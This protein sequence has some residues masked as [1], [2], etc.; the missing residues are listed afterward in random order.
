MDRRL[1]ESLDR[2][3]HPRAAAV[4]G[5]SERRDS[6]GTLLLRSFLDMGF[7][8]DLFPVNPRHDEILGMRCYPDITSL[9]RV[10]DLVVLS[11]PPAAVPGLVRECAAAGVGGCVI[12]T[13]GFSETGRPEGRRLEEEVR[14]A[15]RGSDLRVVGPN[16]MG[17]YSARGKVAL[18]AGMFPVPGRAGMISQSGS[19]SSISFLTGME[20]GILFD[21]IVSSGNELDLNCADFLEYMAEDPAVEIVLAYLEQVRDARRFLETARRMRGKKPLVAIKGGLTLSGERAAASHTAAL[22]GNAEVFRGAAR[23]AGMV[24]A[25]DLAQMLDFSSA[26]LHLPPCGGDRVAVVSAPG[27]LAVNSADAVEWAGLSMARISPRTREALASF[28]PPEGTSLSNP[29]DLGFGAVVPGNYRRALE[30]LDRDPGVD[31]ILAVGS[32][33]ASRE[34]DIGLIRA[35]TDEVLEAKPSLSK[36]LVVVLF[37]SA[38]V[39]P[40]AARLYQ[41]GIPAYLTPTSACLSLR[42]YVDHHREAAVLP[43]G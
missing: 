6:P 8:G 24:L 43:R 4:V 13:A 34:G 1:K 26:L 9:P 35:I 33:P 14:E 32:A 37:P 18:F 38:L 40:Q 16:C 15:L 2:I 21:K 17:I 41:A 39:Q 42:H 36:P 30:L 20:R 27:G 25:D 7:E 31:I 29:V 28:L 11:V 19:I 22:A 3:F 23:Q 12:N 5:V 10:P